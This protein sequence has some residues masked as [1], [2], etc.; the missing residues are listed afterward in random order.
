MSL[1]MKQRTFKSLLQQKSRVFLGDE[2]IISQMSY[3]SLNVYAFF[4]DGC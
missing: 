3:F 2:K 4:L 1:N